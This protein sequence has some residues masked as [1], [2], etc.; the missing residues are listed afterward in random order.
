[1]SSPRYR[2]NVAA[3]I[4]GPDQKILIGERSDVREAWQFPQG[5]V[6]KGESTLEALFRELR[7]EV[8]LKPSHYRVLDSKGPYRYLF[9]DGR[10]KEG[11]DGQEQFYFLVRLTAPGSYVKI[12]TDNPEFSRIRWIEPVDFRLQWL[13]EFKREVYRQVFLDFFGIRPA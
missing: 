12:E 7:E 9:Q 6:R 8:S 13:P 3:I 5:G 1:M 11:F 2:S 10:K 4:Q